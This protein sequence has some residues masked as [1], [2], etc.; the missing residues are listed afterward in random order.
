[1][2][3]V[4]LLKG[5][6]PRTMLDQLWGNATDLAKG[7]QMPNHFTFRQIHWVS[8][9]SPIGTQICQAAGTAR[10][11]QIKGDDQVTW[12]F[13]G[14][15]GTSSNDFH[16]GTELRR[17]LEGAVRVR[18]REQPV[19]DLGPAG[20]AD[21]EPSFAA[22]AKAY[23]MPG[24][25]VDG[26]DVLAVYQAAKEARERAAAGDGP[27]LLE[28]V[29]FRMGPHSSSD[30]PSRYQEKGVGRSGRRRTRSIAS[31]PS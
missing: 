6:P 7:R 22:K 19:G 17:R 13:F 8:I 3:S 31:G 27:T 28:T 16:A 20:A 10:A 15:G 12:A 9:S 25:R 1:M 5:V 29:T 14:D 11:A 26:N 21:G 23:G 18:L 4:A 24:I 30:D 2:H